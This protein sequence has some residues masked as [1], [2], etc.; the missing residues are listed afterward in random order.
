MAIWYVAGN[1]TSSA[2]NNIISYRYSRK[3]NRTG[4][5]KYSISYFNFS[6]SCMIQVNFCARIVS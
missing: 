4:A 3:N 5:N 1:D 6:N 2:N